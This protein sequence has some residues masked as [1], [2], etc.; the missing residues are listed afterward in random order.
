MPIVQREVIL[1]KVLGKIVPSKAESKKIQTLAKRALEIVDEEASKNGARAMLAG[2]LTRDTW[3][4]GKREFD[5]FILFPESATRED[6]EKIGLEVGKRSIARLRG[7]HHVEYAEHPYTCG[8]VKGVDIDVVP[9]FEISSTDKLKSAVDRTPFHVKFVKECLHPEKSNDVRLLKQFCKANGIY[10]ADAKTEGLSGYVCELLV[11]N[12]GSFVGVLEAVLGWHAGYIV[13]MQG[14]YK[15]DQY[16]ELKKTFKGNA[17]ILIDPTDKTRNTAAALSPYNF[18]KLKS[19]SRKFLG[20]PSDKMFFMQ[21]ERPMSLK[22]LS[23]VQKKRESEIVVVVFDPPKVVPDI[24]WPQLRRFSQRIE[25]ILREN[26]FVVLRKDVY[27]DE[28]DFA[29]VLLE[30]ETHKLP[31]VRKRV[32]PSIFDEHGARN[33]IKK[34]KD[35]SKNGPFVEGEFWAVETDRAFRTAKSKLHDSLSDPMAELLGK[36]IPNF[37]AKQLKKK[38]RILDTPKDIISMAKKDPDFGVFMRKYF[39]KESLV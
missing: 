5:V 20:K 30:M 23:T 25:A 3:L 24:L 2:S 28:E 10:G 6:M 16:S 39:E 21:K 7:K 1:K 9:C 17:L 4:P 8:H 14:Y 37:I 18:E 33:F 31:A 13:D 27:S 36:G 32:G 22:E 34:Y 19:V 35:S 11:I 26:E 15:K 38:Y 29:A 12:Y